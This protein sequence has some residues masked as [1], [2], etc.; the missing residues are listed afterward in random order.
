MDSNSKEMKRLK[1]FAELHDERRRQDDQWGGPEWDD[2]HWHSLWIEMIVDFARGTR[3][4]SA[5]R[6]RMVIVGALAV[7]A[8]ESHDRL[9]EEP[10]VVDPSEAG[11]QGGGEEAAEAP[12]ET[13]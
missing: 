9:S 12:E 2:K 5:F 10:N 3:G 11:G 4:S 7:A 13:Q 6:R 8:L 1:I